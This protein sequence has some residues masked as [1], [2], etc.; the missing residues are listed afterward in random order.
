M[1][2]KERRG[3]FSLFLTDWVIVIQLCRPFQCHSLLFFRP[4]TRPCGTI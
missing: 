3:S 4:S 2:R 1:G